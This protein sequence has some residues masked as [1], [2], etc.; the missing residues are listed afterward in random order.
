MTQ[1]AYNQAACRDSSTTKSVILANSVHDT[2]RLTFPA[3]PSAW[4]RYPFNMKDRPPVSAM[5]RLID[6]L[7]RLPGLGKRSAQRVAFY[8]L[9]QSPQE[10]HQLA[11]AILDLKL[12]T[13]HC[14]ICYNLA[15]SDPCPICLD[16]RRDQSTVLVVE[17]PNDVA[18]IEST[19]LFNGV[20]H[21]LMGQLSPLDGIGPGELNIEPLLA[22]I[23]PRPAASLERHDPPRRPPTPVH[24]IVL[25]TNPNLE[26]DGTSLYLATRVAQLGVKVSRLARGLPT[27][28]NLDTVSK[29]VLSDALHGRQ[30]LK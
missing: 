27:G 23:N 10:A 21:V 29:A 17:Q 22:R 8:L 16:P 26:G 5:D 30:A 7:S 3:E 4:V 9:K 28:A 19:G 1:P 2:N 11:Q 25:G 20:Y 15:E 24:E 13:R 14:S 18:A 6:R 12:S